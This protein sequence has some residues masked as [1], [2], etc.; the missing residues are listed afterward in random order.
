VRAR[1][2]FVLALAAAAPVLAQDPGLQARTAEA[3]RV[4]ELSSA[5][6]Q[7][8]QME[9]SVRQLV[10]S[11]R[12]AQSGV[13]P[14]AAEIAQE[15]MFA[16]IRD[17][18]YKPGGFKDIGTRALAQRFTLEELKELRAFYES[19]VARKLVAEQPRM[20]QAT[21]AETSKVNEEMLQGACQRVDSRLRNE[22][23]ASAH[24]MPQCRGGR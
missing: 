15:E 22:R 18:M 21:M 24:P 11:M 5:R 12:A 2:A 23:V 9:A 20:A 10:A 4:F 1:A 3:A 17:A 14:R 13:T 6:Q 19:P 16:G 8:D 7:M